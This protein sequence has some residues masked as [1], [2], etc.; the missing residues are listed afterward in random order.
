MRKWA[1]IL[2]LL[3]IIKIYKQKL[4]HGELTEDPTGKH[5]NVI[6]VERTKERASA[7]KIRVL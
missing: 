7:D 3:L 5:R 2:R 4:Q 6:V 1:T